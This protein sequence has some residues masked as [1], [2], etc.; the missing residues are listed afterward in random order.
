[1][2]DSFGLGEALNDLIERTRRS[3]PEVLIDLRVELSGAVLGNDAAL[4]LYR[5]A[6]EGISNSLRHGQAQRL[7]LTVLGDASA[8][9]LDLTDDGIGLAQD[10][11]ERTGHHGLR[12]MA[13]RVEALGGA[14]RIEPA[15]PSGV[16]LQV[17]VP[18]VM[19][20]KENE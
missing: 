14:F 10:W 19:V 18:L 1:M 17:Q 4:A 8:V 11:S 9:T 5:A 20:T 15:V 2:L 6:Q 12:W 7:Q 3:Q 13:E 16:H